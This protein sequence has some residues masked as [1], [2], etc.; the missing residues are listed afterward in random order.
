[1]TNKIYDECFIKQLKKSPHVKSVSQKSILFCPDFKLKAVLEYKKG[2]KPVQI[3][4]EQ[5]FNIDEF[6]AEYTRNCVRRWVSIYDKF[7][8]EGLLTDRRMNKNKS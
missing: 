6:D 1:M 2:R 8:A 3:F 4:S 7:G 5:G